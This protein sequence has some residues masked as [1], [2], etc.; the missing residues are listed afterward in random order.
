MVL[1]NL[2]TLTEIVSINRGRPMNGEQEYILREVDL[3]PSQ[4]V[5]LR[6]DENLNSYFQRDRSIFPPGLYDGVKFTRINLDRGQLGI[7]IT[8]VG[9]MRDIRQKLSEHNAGV[10]TEKVHHMKKLLKG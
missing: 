5:C 7:D 2:I 6:E 10:N 3:N 8:V 4:I 9:S 1:H